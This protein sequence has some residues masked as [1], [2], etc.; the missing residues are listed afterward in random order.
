MPWKDDHREKANA[1]NREWR[2]THPMTDT[3]RK[4]DAARSYAKV[5]LNRGL[6]TRE[7]CA[8]CE[9]PAQMHHPDYDQPLL[10]VWLCVKHHRDVHDWPMF[11]AAAR[12]PSGGQE[13]ERAIDRERPQPHRVGRLDREVS[14]DD[15]ADDRDEKAQPDRQDDRQDV[16]RA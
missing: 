4:R 2:K 14:Q 13:N 15:R 12:K 6:I 11:L 3:Q 1:Y 9:A 16:D 8:V 7:G 10:I 5:Y